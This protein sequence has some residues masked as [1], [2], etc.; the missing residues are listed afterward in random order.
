M[1]AFPHASHAF[2]MPYAMPTIV[3]KGA[4]MPHLRERTRR[5]GQRSDR[6]SLFASTTV[7]LRRARTL[8]VMRRRDAAIADVATY[9]KTLL[10][11]GKATPGG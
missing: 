4:G 10:P 2:D 1:T 8:E 9:L 7:A 6:R 11:N 5:A 3:V